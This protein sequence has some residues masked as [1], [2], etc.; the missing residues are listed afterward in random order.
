MFGDQITTDG[1]IS[2]PRAIR[3]TMGNSV[4]HR[5]NKYLNHRLEQ[6][7]RGIKQRY[8]PMRGFGTVEAAARFCCAAGRITQLFPFPPH[9]GRSSLS[10]ATTAS[11]S[12]ATNSPTNIQTSSLIVQ[13]AIDEHCMHPDTL[14]VFSV[15]TEP[16]R[17]FTQHPR[18]AAAIERHTGIPTRLPDLGTAGMFCFVSDYTRR[19]A[20]QLGGWR[21]PRYAITHPG[22]SRTEFPPLVRLPEQ[23][24]KWCLLW[25]G[26]VIE[27]K[28][29]MTA[30][31]ALRS[32]PEEA[33]LQIVG[34]VDPAYRH[35]LEKAAEAAGTADRLSFALAARQEVRAYYQQADVTLFTSMIEHEAFGLVP[36]EA[37]ASG[38]PVISTCVGGSG[39]YCFDGINCMRTPGKCRCIGSRYSAACHSSRSPPAACQWR[40][41]DSESTDPRSPGGT[42]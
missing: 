18:H 14:S 13:W 35:S 38:C 23:P 41:T 2:Y 19:R 1:H 39:E 24:W 32:L 11:F 22:V 27:G 26:R 20:E 6:D 3:E 25:I 17:R 21:F 34:P 9:D 42:H 4:E 29:I 28:G 30:V 5:T 31:N 15:L 40:V 33:T 37:M 8:Y 16:I 7:H 10:P 12:P 36:L